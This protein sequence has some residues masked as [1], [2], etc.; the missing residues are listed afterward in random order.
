MIIFLPHIVYSL[1]LSYL[2]S[3]FPF[4]P[5]FT[6]TL[7]P[8]P[9]EYFFSCFSFILLGTNKVSKHSIDPFTQSLFSMILVRARVCVHMHRDGN[10]YFLKISLLP[11]LSVTAFPQAW[12]LRPTLVPCS[13]GTL[14]INYI[15]GVCQLSNSSLLHLET[16]FLYMLHNFC[17]SGFFSSLC[18][19]SSPLSF[20]GRNGLSQ[21][22]ASWDLC[23]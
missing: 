1:D 15:S 11:S 14:G 20:A 2:G 5:F 13:G 3:S 9:L 16:F 10:N 7:N 22:R 18:F 17:P 19:R 12:K 23:L 6:S 8:I 21:A 4:L